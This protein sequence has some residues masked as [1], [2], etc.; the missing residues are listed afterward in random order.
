MSLYTAAAAGLYV[1]NDGSHL[2]L[3]LLLRLWG[4]LVKHCH[5]AVAG[6]CWATPHLDSS[7][8]QPGRTVHT[9]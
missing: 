9:A 2:L 4:R 8:C 6:A 3:L 7:C 1:W 5:V